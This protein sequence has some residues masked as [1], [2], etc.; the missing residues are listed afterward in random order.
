[1]KKRIGASSNEASDGLF[2]D[3]IIQAARILSQGGV[4]AFPTETYY[5]L[6]ADPDNEEALERLFFIKKRPLQKPV[7][8]LIHDL[9]LLASLV[10]TI[11][12]AYEP[13]I[14]RYWPGPLT[15]IFPARPDLSPF[16]TA[17]TETVGIRISPHPLALALGK[18]FGKAMTATSANLSGNS[19]AQFASEILSSFGKNVDYVLDG[20]RSPAGQCS[21]IIGLRNNALCLLRSGAVAVAGVRPALRGGA[22]GK[23]SS[24]PE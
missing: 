6:A 13:L 8:L 5:G 23:I 22:F 17:G 24:R 11:P 12:E 21:T 16:L 4:V 18:V 7:L 10:S 1:M 15:L 14:E 19:P 20:G 9:S 2:E 3:S